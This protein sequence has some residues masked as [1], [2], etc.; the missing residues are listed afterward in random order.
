MGD[1]FFIQTSAPQPVTGAFLSQVGVPA[2]QLFNYSVPLSN[3]S[4]SAATPTIVF[5]AGSFGQP[6]S[7]TVWFDDIRIE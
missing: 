5:Q 3:S 4:Q 2:N 7:G 1:Q 6:F